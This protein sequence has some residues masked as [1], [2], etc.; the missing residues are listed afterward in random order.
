MKAISVI[1]SPRKKGNCSQI[2]EYITECRKENLNTYEVTI[3]CNKLDDT[4]VEKVKEVCQIV[5]KCNVITNNQKQYKK[6]AINHF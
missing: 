1:A 5:K 4:I 2:V 6:L 3:L